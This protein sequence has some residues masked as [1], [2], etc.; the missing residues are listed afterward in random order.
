MCVW[1]FVP[2]LL[3]EN[4]ERRRIDYHYNGTSL[5]NSGFPGG[6][7]SHFRRINMNENGICRQSFAGGRA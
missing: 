2:L 5:S 4:V 3:E 1:L 6:S 7:E